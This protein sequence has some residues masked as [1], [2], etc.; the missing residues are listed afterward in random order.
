[1]GSNVVSCV[2]VVYTFPIQSF[3][4]S[5]VSASARRLA[6]SSPPSVRTKRYRRANEATYPASWSRQ[7]IAIF[8]AERASLAVSEVYWELGKTHPVEWLYL[9]ITHVDASRTSVGRGRALVSNPAVL[10]AVSCLYCLPR[11]QVMGSY[12]RGHNRPTHPP[13]RL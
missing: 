5:S 1:L 2:G 3:P 8:K 7:A 13:P 12:H 4:C 10:D 9:Q 11:L 6:L